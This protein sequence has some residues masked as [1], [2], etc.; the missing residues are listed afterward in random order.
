MTLTP[1]EL[2]ILKCAVCFLLGAIY[3]VIASLFLIHTNAK[4]DKEK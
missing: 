3:G 2:V 4:E 1:N